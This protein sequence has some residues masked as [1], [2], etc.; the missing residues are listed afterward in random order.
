MCHCGSPLNRKDQT[1]DML[2][3]MPLNLEVHYKIQCSNYYIWV[4][5]ST[6]LRITCLQLGYIAN[7]GNVLNSISHAKVV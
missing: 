1:I 6:A 3:Y 2:V 5:I 7:Y 4:K